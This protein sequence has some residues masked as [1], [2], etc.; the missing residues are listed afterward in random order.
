MVFD[1]NAQLWEKVK[2]FSRNYHYLWIAYNGAL[3]NFTIFCQ[4]NIKGNC[5]DKVKVLDFKLASKSDIPIAMQMFSS[6]ITSFAIKYSLYIS[7]RTS[8]NLFA[9]KVS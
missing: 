6:V 2:V 5:S 4:N 8:N 3:K 9:L 1:V 7:N